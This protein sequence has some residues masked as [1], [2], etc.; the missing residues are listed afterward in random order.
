MR[1]VDTL[2]SKRKIKIS[3]WSLL[4]IGKSALVSYG[5]FLERYHMELNWNLSLFPSPPSQSC[6]LC[7]RVL[8]LLHSSFAP[9]GFELICSTLHGGTHLQSISGI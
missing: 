3:L 8:L 2:H 7:F 4:Y 5:V 1:V 6:L 9:L